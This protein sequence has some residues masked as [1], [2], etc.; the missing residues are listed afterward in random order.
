MN[1]PAFQIGIDAKT[2]ADLMINTPVGGVL[3]YEAMSAAI[4]RDVLGQRRS[5]QT[6]INFCISEHRAVFAVVTGVGYRRL[7]DSEAIATGESYIKRIRRAAARGIR[8]VACANYETL[9][10]SDKIR[11]NVN[12]TL[13]AMISEST[14]RS[15][16]QRIEKAVSDSS[17]S[18]PAARA[19]IAALSAI[20]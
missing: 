10:D 14:S 7:N 15:S 18:I 6:A 8:R 11:H 5:I 3:T 4:G 2:I 13:L 9:N 16:V 17:A 12:T 20:A 19:A 1:R